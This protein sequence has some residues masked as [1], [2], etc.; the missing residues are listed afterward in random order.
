MF[1]THWRSKTRGFF[2]SEMLAKCGLFT[3]SSRLGCDQHFSFAAD[4]TTDA[5]DDEAN[6]GECVTNLTTDA[7]T[8]QSTSW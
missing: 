4:G 1:L 5:I 3:L 8:Y 2:V 7:V 6:F